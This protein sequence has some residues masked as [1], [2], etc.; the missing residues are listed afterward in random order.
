MAINDISTL[1]TPAA[2]T[3]VNANQGGQRANR[4]DVQGQ[5]TSA[6]NEAQTE[7][8]AVAVTESSGAVEAV[9]STSGGGFRGSIVDIT[10]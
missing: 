2:T 7:Q 5:S 6:G 8:T 1:A 3:S 9:Q 10:V 4:T